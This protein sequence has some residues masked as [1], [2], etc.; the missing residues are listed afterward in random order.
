MVLETKWTIYIG[1][2]FP[3]HCIVVVHR[4]IVNR[5]GRETHLGQVIAGFKKGCNRRYW[6]LTGQTA[7]EWLGEPATASAHP[8]VR[9]QGARIPSTGSTGR[10]PFFDYGYV[11]V[12]PLREGQLERQR[13][14]IRNNP[15]YRLMRQNYPKWLKLQRASVNTAL[16]L[17]A[18]KS[19]LQRE[20]GAHFFNDETWEKLKRRLLTDGNTIVCDSYG[21]SQ[22]LSNRLLPVVCHRKDAHLFEEHK[23]RCLSAA[24]S[25]SILVSA[26]IAKG[27]QDIIDSAN[28][29]GFPVVTVEDNGFSL[30]YHPSEARMDLCYDNRLLIVSPWKYAYRHVDES[31]SVAEC[32]AMNC[33]VQAICR[34]KDSWWK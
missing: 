26:R 23:T 6:A 4:T 10:P 33:I 9:P 31:I 27:E 21:N 13:E 11:D 18:L 25:G 24:A 2:P 29:Q 22:L 15:R 34:T 16:T 28:H 17:P 19:Y 3:L 32:K 5:N 1:W 8:A 7:Q 12:Q 20:C 14:Y 30:L